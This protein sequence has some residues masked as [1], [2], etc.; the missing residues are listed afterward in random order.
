M[1]RPFNEFVH[2]EDRKR[3]LKQ[4]ADVRSGEQAL[5]FENRYLCKDGSYRWLVWHAAPN[6]GER[7][8]HSVAVDVTAPRQA[9]AKREQRL[10]E[11][12]DALSELR[13]AGP[14]LSVCG[15]CL[16]LAAADDP[17]WN[18]DRLLAA[19][20]RV[21]L[22]HGICPTCMETRLEPQIARLGSR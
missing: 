6:P 11:L 12:E 9:E 7:T 3:T 10:R 17:S 4:N 16:K 2:P 8:I 13:R 5:A 1:S 14:V 18:L 21:R 20:T 15:Y 19:H 22:S